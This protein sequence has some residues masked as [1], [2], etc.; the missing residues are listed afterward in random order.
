MM[1]YYFGTDIIAPTKTIE[2]RLSAFK[3]LSGIADNPRPP[4]KEDNPL[5]WLLGLIVIVIVLSI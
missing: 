1:G 4:N 3:D 5:M 2:R